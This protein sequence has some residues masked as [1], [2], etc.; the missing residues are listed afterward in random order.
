ML[1]LLQIRKIINTF[2][3]MKKIIF[4]I[5][6]FL[7]AFQCETPESEVTCQCY[8]EIVYLN[9][10]NE[11]YLVEKIVV[12]QNKCDKWGYGDEYLPLDNS[13][14]HHRFIEICE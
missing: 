3:V 11:V 5:L 8:N 4:L 13:S 14:F 6:P 9:N 7:L 10:G 12:D 2:E 1:K